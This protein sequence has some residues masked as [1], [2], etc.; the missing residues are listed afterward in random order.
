MTHDQTPTPQEQIAQAREKL[1]ELAHEQWTGWMR[2]LFSQCRYTDMGDAVIPKSSVL[3]WQRQ[4][5]ASYADL[6]ETEKDSDRKEA[7]R[8]LALLAAVAIQTRQ[9]PDVEQANQ[10]LQDLNARLQMKMS[11][12]A[13]EHL[14]EQRKL[15]GRIDW[16]EGTALPHARLQANAEGFQ[17]GW[18]AALERIRQGDGSDELLHLVPKPSVALQPRQEEIA[19]SVECPDVETA[20]R[21]KQ[22]KVNLLAHTDTI[23]YMG[24]TPMSRLWV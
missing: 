19:P 17:T 15:K 9:P 6:S 13:D 10:S 5:G 4:M 8:V 23:Y 14:A 3:H 12:N 21:V 18:H 20:L 1:A 24:E 16:L 2:Y 7:D 22:A 11:M